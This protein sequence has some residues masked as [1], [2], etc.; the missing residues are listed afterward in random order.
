MGT[1]Y[2]RK[3][4]LTPDRRE[5]EFSSVAH[6]LLLEQERPIDLPT[7]WERFA[8]RPRTKRR[9]SSDCVRQA[10]GVDAEGSRDAPLGT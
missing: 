6:L 2:A 8:A 7:V 3:S 9:I 1:P 5:G 4:N 10:Q